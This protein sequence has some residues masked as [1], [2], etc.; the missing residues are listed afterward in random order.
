MRLSIPS[1]IAVIVVVLVAL[2]GLGVGL[3]LW[4]H[5]RSQALPGPGSPLYEQYAEAF[6]VGTAALDVDRYDIANENLSRA[7]EEIPQEPAAWAN[8]GL[9]H[10]RYN[11]LGEAARD[12]QK[13]HELAPNN[14]KIEVLLGL[15][16]ERR[17]A[18]DEA[19]ADLRKA[20]EQNPRDVAAQYTLAQL[21]AKAAAD[22]SD[23]EYQKLMQ[24]ILQIQP[25]NLKVLVELAQ[26]A[27]RRGDAATQKDTLARL[28]RLSSSWSPAT[29]QQ[30]QVVE[31]AAGGP[32]PGDVPTDLLLLNNLLQGERG[33]QRSAIAVSPPEKAVG[34]SLQQFVRLA[35]LRTTPD[36]PDLNLTF[37]SEPPSKL[38]ADVAKERWDVVLPIWLTGEGPPTV[39]VVNASTVRRADGVGASFNYPSGPRHLPPTADG[40][41]G[42]DWDNDARTDL[43]L[44]GAGGLKFWKQG[45]DGTFT[46]VTAKTGL[47][48]AILSGDYVGAW[49]ADIE[50]DGDLDIILAPRAGP[51]LVLRN[52]QDGTFKVLHL[53]P[54]VDGLRAFAWADFDNDGAPD[55]ALLDAKGQVHVFANE[56]SGQFRA[57]VMPKDLGRLLA[58]AAADVNDD[59]V[60][61]LL[62][63]RTDGVIIRLSDQDQGQAWQTAEIARGASLPDRIAPGVARLLVADLDNNGMPDLVAASPRGARVWLG[64]GPD[65]FIPVTAELE[66][67]QGRVFAAEDLTNNGRVDPVALG[68]GGQ[69]LRLANHGTKDYHWQ[70]VRPQANRKEKVAGDNRIN[71]FAIG[72]E[73][74]LRAGTLIQKQMIAAPRVHFGLGQHRKSDLLRIVWPNGYPQVEFAE[75]SDQVVVAE[76][77][78]K[79]SCPFL[80]AWNGQRIEFVTDFMW[81]TPLGMYINAQDKGGFLQ[82]QDWVKIRGDQLVPRNRVYDVRVL[83]NLWETHYYDYMAMIAVDHPADTEVFVDERFAVTPMVPKVFLTTPPRPVAHAWDDRGVDVTNTVRAIDGCYLDTCGRGRFQGV[84]RDHWVEVDLGDDA[85]QEGPLW[86]LAN[87]WVHPTDSSINVSIGQ[88]QHDPPRGLVLEIPDGKGGWTVGRPALGFPAG[89]NKTILVRLDGITSKGVTR[90]FRLRTNM[91]VY[92]DA[93]QF[94]VGL[95]AKGLRQQRLDPDVAELR[96]RGILEMTQANASSPELPHYDRVARVDQRWRDLIG[97]YTRFGDV[98]QLLARIDDRYVILNAGDEIAMQ[99]RVPEGPPAGWK[100]DFVWICDGWVKDGDLNTRF[101]KTVLPLPAHDLKTYDQPPGYLQD[102]PVFRRFPADWRNYHTRY[103]TPSRFERGLRPPATADAE[104]PASK[105][106]VETARR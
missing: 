65:K 81:S 40:V 20:V 1:R 90:H 2:A 104:D 29:R 61:D 59:G 74:E 55:A 13:A 71:S 93:L 45:K 30:L 80:F 82:T 83:A 37:T 103:I 4:L 98:R 41:V 26:V 46:D 88:G 69:P 38:A 79:G 95:D 94:A 22:N 48:A 3:S 24:S 70:Q 86:L 101:S 31:K 12:L 23:A 106:L 54:G 64:E 39:F 10:L 73:I 72:G 51:P 67:F 15:L 85:P 89:K 91:E 99:F 92:W 34:E 97:Y 7:I 78:L 50:M 8:R 84:T 96:H 5:S 25:N 47:D 75:A 66:G 36:A 11:E 57:R 17:G 14:A 77:R 21:I 68:P 105:Q 63:L 52:N 100:R 49:A 42:L 43:L 102:D 9:L 19:V 28:G 62:A 76:Q 44:A 53:F 16:A 32:L 18:L 27:A 87:G 35:P 56:R 58:L 6:E 60:F 33:Y